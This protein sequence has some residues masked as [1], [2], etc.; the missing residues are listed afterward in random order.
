VG[1]GS[2]LTYVNFMYVKVLGREPS[3]NLETACI[4]CSTPNWNMWT[5]THENLE[6]WLALQCLSPCKT[7]FMKLWCRSSDKIMSLYIR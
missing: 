5:P 1:V 2:I 3:H 6:K 4:N 7:V